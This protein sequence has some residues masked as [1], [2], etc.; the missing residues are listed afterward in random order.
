[1]VVLGVLLA[2]AAVLLAVVPFT[3]TRADADGTGVVHQDCGIP[4]MSWADGGDGGNRC[5]D[6]A[7][8]RVDAAVTVALLGLVVTSV[9]F[10]ARRSPPPRRA[11]TARRPPVRPIPPV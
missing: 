2:G 9:G 4:W 7:R 3:T 5:D 11:R 1:M 6:L 8:S 10:V